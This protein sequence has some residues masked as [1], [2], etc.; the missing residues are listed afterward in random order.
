MYVSKVIQVNKCTRLDNADTIVNM[1]EIEFWD[2]QCLNEQSYF[3]YYCYH[4]TMQKFNLIFIKISAK[5]CIP[6]WIQNSQIFL[7]LKLFAPLLCPF[8]HFDKKNM[9]TRRKESDTYLVTVSR[10]RWTWQIAMKVDKMWQVSLSFL[11]VDIF[12]IILSLQVFLL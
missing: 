4:F 1:S 3:Y 6:N 5:F 9:L 11:L 10:H 2:D 7:L 12:F 8:R